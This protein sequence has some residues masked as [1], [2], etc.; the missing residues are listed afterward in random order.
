MYEYALS[1]FRFLEFKE[2]D[3][4]KYRNLGFDMIIY[5]NGIGKTT[6]EKG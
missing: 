4:S 3:E 6:E 1:L 5:T 2:E